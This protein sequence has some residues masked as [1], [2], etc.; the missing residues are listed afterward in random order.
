M[1]EI[2][3]APDG[4]VVGGVVS[5]LNGPPLSDVTVQSGPVGRVGTV[6]CATGLSDALGVYAIETGPGYYELSATAPGYGTA[7]AAVNVGST[8]TTQVPDLVRPYDGPGGTFEVSGSVEAL[9]GNRTGIEGATVTATAGGVVVGAASSGVGG[10]FELHLLW[11]VYTV[12]ATA[13]GYGAF[14]EG[15]TGHGAVT[16][17]SRVLPGFSWTVT[18]AVHSETSGT[19]AGGV[20]IALGSTILNRSASNGNF[21]FSQPNGSYELTAG[22]NLGGGAEESDP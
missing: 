15:V 8:V 22:G 19:V 18:G 16:G 17:L 3:M 1:G 11:G 7:T 12:Q 10:S 2:A 5:G 6:G 4:T 20:P 21:S 9:G 13:G 14:S